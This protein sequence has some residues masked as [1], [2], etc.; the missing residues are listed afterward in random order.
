MTRRTPWTRTLHPAALSCAVGALLLLQVPL[1]SAQLYESGSTG[2]LGPLAPTEDVV[3]ALPEDGVLHYTSIDVPAG[4]TVTFQRNADNTA[5]WLLASD[6]VIIDGTI[7]VSGAG[8]KAAVGLSGISAL[9]G[10]G[11][12]GGS[13]GASVQGT[14]G[15]YGVGPGPGAGS[16]GSLTRASGGA[17]PVAGGGKTS[18]SSAGPGGEPFGDP[19]YQLIHGGS[20]GGSANGYAGGGGGGGIT[21]AGSAAIT[22]NGQVLA[23]G[24]P[25]WSNAAAGGG[26][27]VRVVAAQVTGTGALDAMANLQCTGGSAGACGGNGL[28]R[29]ETYDLTGTLEANAKP[30]AVLALPLKS[31]PF[32]GAERPQLRIAEVAGKVPLTGTAMGH[33]MQNPGVSLPTE[34]TVTINVEAR[35]VEPGTAVMVAVNTLGKSRQT[36]QTSPLDGEFALSTATVDVSIPAGHDLGLIEAWIPALPVPGGG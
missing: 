30:S 1:A 11:G 31:L 33:A 2:V 29:V 25:G 23:R 16:N 22:I 18:S 28:I 26:G 15:M 5:V 20:G 21:I 3:I 4:V 12:P 19:G 14:I 36:Y 17:S 27:F 7:D 24:G 32:P 35:F 13:D 34:T 10:V 8:G 9:G 6:D